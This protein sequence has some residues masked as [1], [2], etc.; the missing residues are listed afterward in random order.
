M[1]GLEEFWEMLVE[2][3]DCITEIPADRWS[4]AHF[5]DPTPQTPG[6]TNAKHGGFVGVFYDIQP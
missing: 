3:K 1:L 5:Y 4:I 2:G 6:K